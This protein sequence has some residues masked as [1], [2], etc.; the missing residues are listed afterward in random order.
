M[1]YKCPECG[2]ESDSLLI[3]AWIWVLA[4][5]EG[6]DPDAREVHNGPGGDHEWD[7][8]SPAQCVLCGYG[9]KLKDFGNE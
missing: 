9:G 4:S 7:D 2:D 6:S 5:E 3:R 1:E 8:D